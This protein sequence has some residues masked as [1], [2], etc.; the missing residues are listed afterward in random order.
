[1]RSPTSEGVGFYSTIAREKVPRISLFG[2][3]RAE[4]YRTG[5]FYEAGGGGSSGGGSGG[6]CG[7]P[8]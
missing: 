7:G 2:T 6:P 4:K 8:R 3:S 1:M 5:T